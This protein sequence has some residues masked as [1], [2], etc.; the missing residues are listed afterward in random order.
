[1]GPMIKNMTLY[2]TQGFTWNTYVEG[3]ILSS[4]SCD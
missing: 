3:K 1:M 4:Q 2:N